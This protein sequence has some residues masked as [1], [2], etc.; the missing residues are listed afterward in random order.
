MPFNR[1]K[2][3]FLLVDFRFEKIVLSNL[4]FNS[5]LELLSE[6][7]LCLCMICKQGRAPLNFLRTGYYDRSAG[8]VSSRTTGSHW[9]SA[10]SASAADGRFLV[11]YSALVNPQVIDLRGFGFAIRCV[12]REG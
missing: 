5:F 9:W 3:T 7:F 8:N 12:V 11:T 2:S 4:F 1:E 6:S 10:T